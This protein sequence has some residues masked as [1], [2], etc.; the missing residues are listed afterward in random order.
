MDELDEITLTKYK[1]SR[2]IWLFYRMISFDLLIYYT[3]SYLFL[4]NVKGLSSAQI[5]FADSFYPLFKMCF[6]IPCTILIQKIGKRNSLILANS[7]ISVYILLVLGLVNTS[8]Y[9]IAN[10]FC[11]MGFVIKEMS[12]CNLLYDYLEDRR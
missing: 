1:K 6:Q 4:V 2:K 12:D 5:I 10:V 8:T 3:I 7:C 9:I 11:A